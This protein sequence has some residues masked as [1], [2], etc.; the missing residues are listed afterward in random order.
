M[1]LLLKRTAAVFSLAVLLALIG[2]SSLTL[3]YNQL[4]LLAGLWADRY[5]DLDSGQERRLKEKLQAWQAWHR[6]EELPQ[7]LALVRQAQAALDD[8]V[9]QDELLALERGARASV[10]RSLQHAAPL[11]APLLAE[12]KPEQWQHLQKK[13]DEKTEEWREK[14]AGRGGPDERAKRYTNNLQRWLGDLDRPARRQARADAEGWHFDL[15]TMAQARAARQART[16]EALRAWS[17][18]DLAGGT[19]LLMRN[20]QPLPAEQPYRDQVMASLVKLLNSLTPEQRRQVHQ[21]W[22]QWEAELRSLQ[23]G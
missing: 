21:H 16:L 17:R 5:L 15:P 13:M 3:A 8:G 11:A 10:E 4:P 20:L 19:G 7:W 1:P 18:Q 22:S 14:N 23:Q 2:C 12:L 6:R 9:T